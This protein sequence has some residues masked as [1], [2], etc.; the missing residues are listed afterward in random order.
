MN[1]F[2]K[3]ILKYK[4]IIAIIFIATFGTFFI[5]QFSY[6]TLTNSKASV[7]DLFNQWDVIRYLIVADGGY[8]PSVAKDPSLIAVFPLLPSLISFLVIFVDNSMLAALIISNLAFA[9][10]CFY[11]YKL[12]MFEKGGDNV[13][14]NAVLF[15]SIFPTAYFFHTGYTESLFLAFAIP[16]FYYARKGNWMLSGILGM[17]SSLVRITS[18]ALFAGLVFEYLHQKKFK[19][20]NVRKDFIW[21]MI[22]P[23]GLI[24][25]AFINYQIFGD[26]FEFIGVQ[27]GYFHRDVAPFW[28]GLKNSFINSQ[29]RS[30]NENLMIGYSEMF[31]GIIGLVSGILALKYLRVSYAIYMI[32]ALFIVTFNSFWLGTPRYLLTLF[33]MFI[34]MSKIS[35]SRQWLHYIFVFFSLTLFVI[36]LS[37]FV[38]GMWAF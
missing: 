6:E 12:V 31:A 25:Y 28:E 8:F 11:L 4:K 17:F 30:P 20:K 34:I 32:V 1:F 22:I 5:A 37:M 27:G 13:A 38:R 21:L 24:F 23:L 3:Q 10:A 36:F 33:P 2:A 18:V 29:T 35:E 9:V 26:P 7:L 15:L 19:L 14:T 16:S